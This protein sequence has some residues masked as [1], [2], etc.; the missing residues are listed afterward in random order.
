MRITGVAAA[1]LLCSCGPAGAPNDAGPTPTDSAAAGVYAIADWQVACLPA[2]CTPSPR[3][4]VTGFHGERGTRAI[5]YVTESSTTR[6]VNFEAGVFGGSEDFRFTATDLVVPRAGG[7]ATA[8]AV[9]VQDGSLIVGGLAHG[10]GTPTGCVVM[11]SFG[12]DTATGSP[13]LEAEV[14]CEAVESID[15]PPVTRRV[16]ASAGSTSPAMINFFDCRGL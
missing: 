12:T 15:D 7:Y 2:S 10:S 5:C 4:E 13:L 11:V 8:G 3:R 16:S 6:T 9:T 14:L 1:L